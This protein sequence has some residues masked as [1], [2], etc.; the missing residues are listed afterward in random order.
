MADPANPGADGFPRS[1]WQAPDTG[2]QLAPGGAAAA[3]AMGVAVPEAPAPAATFD[4]APPVPPKHVPVVVDLSGRPL[5]RTFDLQW[6]KS[7]DGVELRQVM[8][9]RISTAEMVA[10]VD[11]V[12]NTADG[13]DLPYPI[14]R[15]VDGAPLSAAEWGALDTDDTEILTKDGNNFLPARWRTASTSAA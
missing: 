2:I 14:F 5:T 15:R 8:V 1:E 11:R 6:P 7:V 3:R 13:D 12:R 9:Q 10:F 4:P